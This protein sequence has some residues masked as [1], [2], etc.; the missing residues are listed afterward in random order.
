MCYTD[1]LG[2][3]TSS[4][5]FSPRSERVSHPQKVK[6]KKPSQLSAKRQVLDVRWMGKHPQRDN[7]QPKPF[8]D[9]T[10]SHKG[11]TGSTGEAVHPIMVAND[12]RRSGVKVYQGVLVNK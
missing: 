9:I 5:I 7:T 12:S 8:W 11:W 1:N 3:C 2:G 4:L 10:Q 6:G